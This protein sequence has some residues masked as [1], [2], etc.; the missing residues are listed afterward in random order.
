MLFGQEVRS[1]TRDE[2]IV[3][4]T[5]GDEKRAIVDA[6]YADAHAGL[7]R[8]LRKFDGGLAQYDNLRATISALAEPG[9]VILARLGPHT[10]GL[11]R[12]YMYGDAG[13]EPY[14][15]CLGLA[16][17]PTQPVLCGSYDEAQD[18]ARQAIRNAGLPRDGWCAFKGERLRTPFARLF[19]E[20]PD[21]EVILRSELEEALNAVCQGEREC[22]SKPSARPRRKSHG[23]P[24]R[25]HPPSKRSQLPRA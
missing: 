11:M 25:A 12:P 24:R 19:V 20:R 4:W 18:F 3:F 5:D 2:I 16:H 21:G 13:D 23:R 1:G 7:K 22:R 17:Q 9:R 8:I 15:L 14:V 10:V 6:D